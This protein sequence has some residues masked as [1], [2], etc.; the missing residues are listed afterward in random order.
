M[1]RTKAAIEPLDDALSRS[2]AAALG[3]WFA[4]AQRD[5]PWRRTRDPYAIWVSEIM[6]QQTRVETVQ[7]YYDAFL[8]RFPTVQELAA[9]EQQAVLEA[10]SG[11]GYY[12][13]ARLLHRGAQYVVEQLEGQIPA[14]AEELRAIPGVG[15]YTAGAIGSIAFDRPNPL[16]DGNVARVLSRVERIEEPRQQVATARRHWRRVA[17]ILRHGSPRVL[18]QALMELGATVCTP[19]S[20]RCLLCPVREVCGARASGQVEQIPAV[21]KKVASPCSSWVALGVVWRGRLLMIQ[22]PAEGLLADMW[23]LPLVPAPA[24]PSSVDR[25]ALNKGF[26][27]PL[28]WADQTLPMVRHVFTHRTWEMHPL[29]ARASRKPAWAEVDGDRQC[30]VEPGQRPP[31]GIPR[32]TEKLLER[33]GF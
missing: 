14:R 12:R 11:L 1:G 21:R 17:G 18:A 19:R 20:P 6:L 22:R 10:W 25:E 4:Q 26:A 7:R 33:L 31:G 23:C 28:R 3:P 27:V 15:E 8:E 24:E 29:V 30:L 16:V 9:A 13:R 2:L 32:V 5:M